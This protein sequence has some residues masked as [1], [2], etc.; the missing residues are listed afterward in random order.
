[1][2]WG[3]GRNSGLFARFFVS[4]VLNL[5]CEIDMQ[6][7]LNG[8]FYLDCISNLQFMLSIVLHYFSKSN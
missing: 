6:I 8:F 2:K 5:H 7:Y 1:M 3:E 4:N